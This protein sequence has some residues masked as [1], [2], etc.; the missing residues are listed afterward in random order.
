MIEECI[1]IPTANNDA[2]RAKHQK[3]TNSLLHSH[4]LPCCA[5]LGYSIQLTAGGNLGGDVLPVR[6]WG[7]AK[8]YKELLALHSALVD[9]LGP[10]VVTLHMSPSVCLFSF[11]LLILLSSMQLPISRGSPLSFPCFLFNSFGFVLC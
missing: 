11:C 4:T 9:K 3:T 7:F 6:T 10:L 2:I 1:C 8:R 5:C